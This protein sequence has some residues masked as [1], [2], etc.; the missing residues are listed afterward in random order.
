MNEATATTI[1]RKTRT[2]DTTPQSSSLLQQVEID[3]LTT[4]PPL[5]PSKP[6]S[7]PYRHPMHGHQHSVD[8]GTHPLSHLPCFPS[9][10]QGENKDLNYRGSS[11]SSSSSHDSTTLPPGAHPPVSASVLVTRI[12]AA[13]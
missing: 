5:R 8:M 4:P 7:L 9:G 11:P 2:K 10:P 6:A 1:V 13:P 3:L 12:Q